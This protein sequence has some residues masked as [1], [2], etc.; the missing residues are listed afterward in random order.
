MRHVRVLVADDDADHRFLTVRALRD[1]ADDDLELTIDT[2]EDGEEA[3]DYLHKRGQ[4]RQRPRPHL[5]LLDLKMPKVGGL[6]VLAQLQTD[7]DL[8]RI[9][10]VVLTSSER[11]EDVV[12]TYDLGGNSFITKPT[13][14]AGFREGLLRLGDYWTG[15]ASL[16]NGA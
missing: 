5:V 10:T 4:Y 11:P 16:P 1:L 9:P 12:A 6:D 13:S 2:V 7:D 15:L 3:L 14:R 8:R